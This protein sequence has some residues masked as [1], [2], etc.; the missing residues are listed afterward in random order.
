MIVLTRA[1]KV[2]DGLHHK[3]FLLEETLTE[4]DEILKERE[5]GDI[6]LSS[7]SERDKNSPS[8]ASPDQKRPII[9][10]SMEKKQVEQ[11]IEEDR[12]RHKRLRETMW[13]VPN[14]ERAKPEWEK[15]WEET[16]DWGDDD[17][18]LASEEA[19][20]LSREWPDF[21]PHVKLSAL[22]TAKDLA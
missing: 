9:M 16:S 18:L 14:M 10:L 17:D 3:G 5:T 13:A 19:E 12:E 6:G 2:L 15:I 11:R 22:D 8:P 7:P 21:C 4:I 20:E 1:L